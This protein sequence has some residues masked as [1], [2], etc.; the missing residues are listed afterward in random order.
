MTLDSTEPGDFHI[1]VSRVEWG[2]RIA[3]KLPRLNTPV[4]KVRYTHTNTDECA[5][6]SECLKRVRDIQRN[7]MYKGYN[8]IMYK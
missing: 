6:E 1:L 8:D 7:H 3:K 2:A 4:A 5:T